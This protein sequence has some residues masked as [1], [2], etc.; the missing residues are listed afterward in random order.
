MSLFT[1]ACYLVRL[2]Y[3]AHYVVYIM[4][5]KAIGHHKYTCPRTYGE[6]VALL[7]VHNG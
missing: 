3:L 2:H 5:L 6:A 7:A 4:H 1:A